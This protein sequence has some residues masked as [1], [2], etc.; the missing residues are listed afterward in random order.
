LPLK[1]IYLDYSRVSARGLAKFRTDFPG[2]HVDGDPRPS[3]A[4][5][6]LTAGAT[7]A[8]HGGKGQDDRLVKKVADLPRE[9]FLVRRADCSGVKKPLAELLA[10]LSQWREYEFERLE[11]LDL[12]GCAIDDLAFVPPLQSL[13]ELNVAGTKVADAALQALEN[14]PNLRKADLGRTRVTGRGLDH[15]AK[16]PKLAE[17]SLAGSK[18][19]DLFAEDVGTLTKLERL[20]LAGCTFSDAGLKHLAGLSKLKVLD[21]AGTQVTAAGVTALQKALAKCRILSGPAAK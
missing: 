10:R 16:L 3:A 13:R 15:L 2:A 11:A 17:L 12:S 4:E 5:D 1:K 19:Y 21:L 8:I 20:S 6:L 7:L 14:L 18:V 9:P